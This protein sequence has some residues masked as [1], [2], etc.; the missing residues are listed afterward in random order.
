[1]PPRSRLKLVVRETCDGD[2]LQ[3]TMF[4]TVVFTLEI[5]R[6]S[7][8]LTSLVRKERNNVKVHIKTIRH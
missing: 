6:M 1:M 8:C 2:V 3:R 7:R 5:Q 4:D